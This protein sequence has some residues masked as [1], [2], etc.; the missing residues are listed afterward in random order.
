MIVDVSR[1][2]VYMCILTLLITR[3]LYEVV[4]DNVVTVCAIAV[5]EVVIIM[6]LTGTFNNANQ[7]LRKEVIYHHHSIQIT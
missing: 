3:M 1:D 5:L 6:W 2:V 7:Q 4:H